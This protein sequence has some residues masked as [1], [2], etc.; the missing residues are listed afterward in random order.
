[1]SLSS[2]LV[3]RR[4]AYGCARIGSCRKQS[5]AIKKRIAHRRRAGASTT[6]ASTISSPIPAE[7]SEFVEA[8]A[9]EM[10]KRVE[11]VEVSVEGR[12]KNVMTSLVQSN[13]VENGEYHPYVL[14]HG[15]DS[16]CLEYRR[17]FPKLEENGAEVYAL[18]LLGWGFT[19]GLDD[20]IGDYSPEAKC[21]HMYAWWKQNVNRPIVLAGASLGGAAAIEFASRHPEAVARLV[22]IDAQGFIDGIGPMGMLPTPIA[23]AGVDILKT[24]WLRS[25]ANKMAYFDQKYATDDAQNVGRLHT[26]LPQWNDA[27][28]NELS[29][30]GNN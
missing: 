16:S 13:K 30:V 1:M 28:L 9:I 2:T 4:G 19:D 23:K 18:D 8:A 24:R 26:L 6:I 12:E 5:S 22:L 15:F 3:E 25:G 27:T 7:V 29:N 14:L 11:V 17:L 20:G 10:A 21:A